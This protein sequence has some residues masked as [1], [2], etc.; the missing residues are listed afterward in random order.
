MPQTLFIRAPLAKVAGSTKAHYTV[1]SN[2]G[3]NKRTTIQVDA[4]NAAR[5]KLEPVFPGKLT[6]KVDPAAVVPADPSTD[7]GTILGSLYLEL[8]PKGVTELRKDAPTIGYPLCFAYLNVTL[9]AA[10]FTGTVLTALRKSNGTY[11]TVKVGGATLTT[12]GQLSNGFALGQFSIELAPTKASSVYTFPNIVLPAGAP[13]ASLEFALGVRTMGPVA[14]PAR[15]KDVPSDAVLSPPGFAALPIPYFYRFMRHLGARW[16][17]LAATGH[18]THELYDA[19]DDLENAAGLGRWRRLR[20]FPTHPAGTPGA[21]KRPD[22]VAPMGTYDTVTATADDGGFGDLWSTGVSRVGEVYQQRDDGEPFNLEADNRGATV[23][24]KAALADAL[25]DSIALQW[26]A[27]ASAAQDP[28]GI[29]VTGDFPA[30]PDPLIAG[31]DLEHGAYDSAARTYD[32]DKNEV[33]VQELV[34]PLQVLLKTFGF[35]VTA[36]PSAVY[37]FATVSAV[38]EFQR[39]A[40]TTG[41]SVGGV[42]Q[43]VAVTFAGTPNGRFDNHTRQ[44]MARW[45]DNNYQSPTRFYSQKRDNPATRVDDVGYPDSS[46]EGKQVFRWD[47]TEFGTVHKFTHA[48]KTYYGLANPF[49]AT[50]LGTRLIDELNGAGAANYIA[51]TWEKRAIVEVV[52]NEARVFEA[53]NQ[54]DDAF[55][56]C[57]LFQWTTGRYNAIRKEDK[58]GELPGMASTLQPADIQRLFGA[59]GLLSTDLEGGLDTAVMYGRWTFGGPTITPEQKEELRAFRWAHRFIIACSDLAFRQNQFRHA[60]SRLNVLQNISLN[61]NGTPT[62]AG[63]LLQSEFL[64]AVGLDHHVNRPDDVG[65]ALQDVVDAIAAP[66]QIPNWFSSANMGGTHKVRLDYEARLAY[67]IAATSAN[68]SAAELATIQVAIPTE[69]TNLRNLVQTAIADPN[70]IVCDPDGTLHSQG[71]TDLTQAQVDMIAALYN[72]RRANVRRMYHPQE[73]WASISNGGHNGALGNCLKTP[74]QYTP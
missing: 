63:Q 15:M 14:Q 12:A 30:L 54:Y 50:R 19:L 74:R 13:S 45:R 42:A 47:G 68:L 25:A 33:A 73:R 61:W 69:L 67:G 6:F 20:I 18:N 36:K 56:S 44:E 70:P 52:W 55:L 53:I 66:D 1:T 43:V 38:R 62:T 29:D 34:G 41:R 31:V 39:E 64:C 37:D 32:K 27:P 23:Q 3:V 9:N 26:V 48:G 35:G 60:L 49:K 8:S 2:Y 58:K 65:F 51:Q 46:I 71:Q 57:G 21:E 4:A 5:L 17:A 10:F 7:A 59:Y 22:R 16:T 72:W 40:A 24:L 11:K 28:S